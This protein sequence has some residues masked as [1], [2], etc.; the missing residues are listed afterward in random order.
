MKYLFPILAFLIL[1]PGFATAQKYFTRN[2]SV[3]F[4]ATAKNSPERI[5]AKSKSGTLVLDLKSGAIE[6]A[7]L[8]KGLLFER[9]LMQEHFNENY[10]ESDKYPKAKF[11]GKI[12]DPSGI[13]LKK[14]GEYTT[15]VTGTL[16]MHGKTKNVSYPVS[17]KVKGGK[18]TAKTTFVVT[19]SDYDISVP[20]M[21]A[22]KVGRR[23]EVRI[24]AEIKP[25]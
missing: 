22:D 9:A 2:A 11:K 19:L 7:V 4:D 3:Y 14:D 15:K 8:V 6:S 21:V 5:E 12:A 25:L 16:S 17:F 23:A 24:N 20:S 13:N 1:A 18:V 10:M